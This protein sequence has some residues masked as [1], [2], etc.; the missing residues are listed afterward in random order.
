MAE[1]EPYFQTE[2]ESAFFFHFRHPASF[3]ILSVAL[4]SVVMLNVIEL[5]VA[6]SFAILFGLKHFFE[7]FVSVA[8]E[9]RLVNHQIMKKRY[10]SL[11]CWHAGAMTLNLITLSICTLSIYDT[12]H[13]RR[14]A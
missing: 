5:S 1:A 7:F 3:I 14:A 10:I 11:P 6:P 2:T 4:M 12:R 8:V 13:K 9:K